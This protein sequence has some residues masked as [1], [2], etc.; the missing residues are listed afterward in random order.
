MSHQPRAVLTTCRLPQLHHP[1]HWANDS[2]PRSRR[3]T[4][5]VHWIGLSCTAILFGLFALLLF[6]TNVARAQ[7]QTTYDCGGEGEAPCPVS[8]EFF[9]TNG[10]LFCDRGLEATDFRVLSDVQI[11]GSDWINLNRADVSGLASIIHDDWPALQQRIGR[12]GTNDFL[13]TTCPGTLQGDRC[14][15]T[16]P[17]S[18]VT[19]PG[20]RFGNLCV[21]TG[22]VRSCT[23]RIPPIRVF[24]R[25]IVPSRT[26]GGYRHP[27]TNICI[28]TG[29]VSTCRAT[30]T[31]AIRGIAAPFVQLP[32]FNRPGWEIV[33][34]VNQLT[35][36]LVSTV[37]ALP[38]AI[39]TPPPPPEF[40]FE[41]YDP[42]NF[43]LGQFN[44]SLRGFRSYWSGNIPYL[45][46][47]QDLIADFQD[48]PGICVNATRVQAP[49]QEF[50]GTWTDWALR[51]QHDLA[52][53][54][55]FN[56]GTY[57][58]A[59]NAYN[60]LADGYA[61]SNQIFS[62]TDQLSLGVRVLTLDLHWFN[63]HLRLCH[64]NPEH[65][66][67]S[68]TD[69]LYT[70]G[71]KEIT[72][73]LRANP[74]EVIF[75]QFEDRAEGH[76]AYV[77]DPIA[78]YLGD[79][80]YRPADGASQGFH[81]RANEFW[82]SLRELRSLGKQVILSSGDTHGGTW[83]WD[84]EANPFR[85]DFSGHFYYTNSDY[86]PN[87]STPPAYNGS[88]TPSCWSYEQ[89]GDNHIYHNF[90]LT[91]QIRATDTSTNTFSHT[92]EARSFLDPLTDFTGLTDEND[93]AQMVS[94]PLFSIQLDHVHAKEQTPQG[95][96][97]Q[98]AH[99]E[100]CRTPDERLTA[101]V[102]SWRSGDR[103]DRGDAA[104]FNAS[105]ARW[106]ST[107][108]NEVHHFACAQPRT[109]TP[110]TWPNPSGNEWRITTGTGPWF[111][112]HQTCQAEFGTE[113][114]VFAVP[115][116]G[117]QNVHLRAV[118]TE[119]RDVWLNYTDLVNEGDWIANSPLDM[120]ENLPPLVN[121]D[122]VQTE[123]ETSV[124]IDVL[125]ND[126]DPEGA[127]L[128]VQGLTQPAQGT[129]ML[130]DDGTVRYTPAPGFTGTD[131]FGY[132][133]SDLVMSSN[134]QV[135][136]LVVPANQPPTAEDDQATTDE[137]NS[138]V[139]DVG[140]NDSDPEGATLVIV[141]TDSPANGNLALFPSAEILYS[142]EPDFR[143]IDTF[144]YTISDGVLTDTARVTVTVN[145]LLTAIWDGGGRT[146]NWSEVANWKPDAVPTGED[147]VIFDGTSAKDVVLD[148]PVTIAGVQIANGYNGTINLGDQLLT[149]NGDFEQKGGTINADR[150]ILTVQGNFAVNGGSFNP[151]T[152]KLILEPTDDVTL[153]APPA[154]HSLHI[155]TGP[156][157]HWKFDDR[158][159]PEVH[160]ASGFGHT[161]MRFSSTFDEIFQRPEWNTDVFGVD[162]PHN[163]SM[164]VFDGE[165]DHLRIEPGVTNEATSDALHNLTNNLSVMAWV[166]PSEQTGIRRIVAHARTEGN[167][168]FGFGTNGSGL[169]FT[170]F[171]VRDYDS[172]NINLPL[173]RWS[174]V[175]AVM[176]GNNAVTFYVNGQAVETVT[177]GSPGRTNTTETIFIGATT[178]VN[179]TARH[180]FF[181][182]AIDDVR[183]YGRALSSE[184]MAALA[185]GQGFDGGTVTLG[186]SLT[187][188]GNLILNAGTLDVSNQNHA[189]NIGGDLISN[190]LAMLQPR[191]GTVTLN[192]TGLQRLDVD[193][194]T[195]YRLV[196]ANTDVNQLRGHWPLDEVNGDQV[197]GIVTP[198]L[199]GSGNDGFVVGAT[200]VEGAFEGS[201][202]LHFDGTDD[203]VDLL[204]PG[205]L[206]FTERTTLAAWIRPEA[207][208]SVRNII[209]HGLSNFPRGEVVLRINNG[210]Y[211]VGSHDGANHFVS[212][213]IPPEDLNTWVHLAGL[214]DGSHW[215][216]YRNGVEMAANELPVGAVPVLGHWTIGA[217]EQSRRSIPD[218]AT[219]FPSRVFAGA[220]DDVR[221]YARNL[222]LQEI[223]LL[224]NPNQQVQA[225]QAQ[226]SKAPTHNGVRVA[227]DLV[228]QNDLVLEMG[229]LDAVWHHFTVHVGGDLIVEEGMFQAGNSTVYFMGNED[230]PAEATATID[231]QQITVGNLAVADGVTLQST[232]M[233]MNMG[234]LAN[235]Q[236]VQERQQIAGPGIIS[237]GLVDATVTVTEV[238][239]LTAIT[240]TRVDA[241][242]P[243]DNQQTGRY[244]RIETTGNQYR[245]ALT[246]RHN[247][248]QAPGICR[249]QE[250]STFDWIQPVVNDTVVTRSNITT[251]DGV[252][253]VCTDPDSVGQPMLTTRLYLPLVAR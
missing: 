125:A 220:I 133:V 161:S 15:A 20:L 6:T 252:W 48:P 85:T 139:I 173:G 40:A 118:N 137:N 132:T 49:A 10:N 196:I 162:A 90:T 222:T 60:S 18:A 149:I 152:S 54:E 32:D 218:P 192:G 179:S 11:N 80:V 198:D 43:N 76:D 208:D 46:F 251:L 33:N 158:D 175:A 89:D 171:G 229:L 214:Y 213:P 63:D 207:T 236:Q 93:M 203:F 13:A 131:S 170:T 12:L 104:L 148:V 143:G 178:P 75:I 98:D 217:R 240:I 248:R 99:P 216:L 215:R 140:A 29:S 232:A 7:G 41:I 120:A 119:N 52:Q 82:P 74:G 68:P 206:F 117:W 92:Y 224:V 108:P 27:E 95:N 64:G 159:G 65:F 69:R 249:H 28:P 153:I 86:T 180:E 160:D 209:A 35:G 88:G 144:G 194:L 191:Q 113:G 188:T 5:A 169:R 244:W 164:L 114:F 78:R 103:G 83:I 110:D 23:I 105:D 1:W 238:G 146:N 87:N 142:P 246:L 61:A 210:T 129:A 201:Q 154:L 121:N 37:N 150:G 81:N 176:D 195:F 241:N 182:G 183:I 30:I 145:T 184:Q 50:Q 101:A 185:T 157:A 136:I 168:G 237:F 187:L 31:P 57:V 47:A 231:A 199:S 55:P 19:G 122:T 67:C 167:R 163:D 21:P 127:P 16:P 135:G 4:A 165:D 172:R 24:G 234:E 239:D 223:A 100:T 245:A 17:V 59:H 62:L 45:S 253:I 116:N 124:T 181:D 202:A 221:I 111:Q 112:G 138:I 14:W 174:H 242:H 26:I 233:L 96:C 3:P 102:W 34:D 155:G 91:S 225:S 51:N 147:T 189:I 130:N 2:P 77:N 247:D 166:R 106:S 115:V 230:D 123:A 197:D 25:V 73:W 226:A 36:N 70:N 84:A 56:W 134:A 141:G 71:I 228:V 190:D 235:Q 204:N 22:E 44:N 9:W 212:T 79:L 94:C 97:S 128:F 243:N 151:G 42:G 72:T 107:D 39:G 177:H 109:D 8:T 211:E 53:D 219:S 200:L 186:K 156:L 227:G 193:G 66:G 126:L 38:N 205:A 58:G 250:Q